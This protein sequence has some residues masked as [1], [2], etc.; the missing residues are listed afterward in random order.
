M[1]KPIGARGEQRWAEAGRA[2][3][4]RGARAGRRLVQQHEAIQRAGRFAVSAKRGR[5]GGEQPTLS[6]ATFLAGRRHRKMP[7][8]SIL[9]VQ[10]ER[11]NPHGDNR[12][13]QFPF[14]A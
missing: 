6:T 11:D 3:A 10:S 13:L 4:G 5:P 2:V 1:E 8:G 14:L 12:D 7:R 9:H